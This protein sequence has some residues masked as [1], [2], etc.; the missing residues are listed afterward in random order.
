VAV[1]GVPLGLVMRSLPAFATCALVGAAAFG[2]YGAIDGMRTAAKGKPVNTVEALDSV[3]EGKPVEFQETHMRGFGVPVFGK[4][5]WVSD[6]GPS[7]TVSNPAD[8]ETF[9]WMQNRAAK[10]DPPP[11]PEK[12]KSN[13]LIPQ[14]HVVLVPGGQGEKMLVYESGE[15]IAPGQRPRP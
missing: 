2:L 6:R 15:P 7:S 13:L 12:P 14:P 1:V 4:V 8:L 9:F 11:P 5:S 3:L 10:E